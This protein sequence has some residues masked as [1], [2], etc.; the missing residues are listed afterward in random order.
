M[1]IKPMHFIAKPSSSQSLVYSSIDLSFKQL[2]MEMPIYSCA[3]SVVHLPKPLKKS[4]SL[5]FHPNAPNQ[6]NF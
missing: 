1:I 5:I 4:S 2:F 6:T 3:A